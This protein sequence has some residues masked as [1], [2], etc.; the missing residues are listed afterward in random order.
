MQVLSCRAA[1]LLNQWEATV[2]TSCEP[3]S[4][5]SD[6]RCY[7]AIAIKLLYTVDDVA[8]LL[9][10]GRSTVEKL[11]QEGYLAS[12]IVQGTGRA[13]RISRKQVE[14]FI[15]QFDGEFPVFGKSR[16]PKNRRRAA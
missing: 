13:R 1:L 9:S 15:E 14:A 3:L 4:P 16:V 12:G 10:I 11:I 6:G 7:D 8:A 5:D 2:A